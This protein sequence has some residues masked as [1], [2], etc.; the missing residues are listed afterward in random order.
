MD[1]VWEDKPANFS[2]VR[3]MLA[4]THFPDGGLIVLPELFATGF[5]MNSKA[6]VEDDLGE[7][8]TFLIELA[9]E[10]SAHVIGGVA[11]TESTG[12]NPSNCSV[13]SSPDGEII[14]RYQKTHPFSLGDEHEN[15]SPGNTVETVDFNGAR[16]CPTVCYDL[17]FP[18][19]F[20]IG[21][22]KGAE[23]FVVIANWPDKRNQHWITLLQAR[24][25]ENQAFV[26]GVN[27][28]GQDPNL[29]YLGSTIAVNFLGEIIAD[30][31]T[32]AG[33]VEADL[34]L[35]EVREWRANFPA[36]RDIHGSLS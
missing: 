1:I 9:R 32:T 3:E 20:R 28:S 33:V 10:K 24:A 5:T 30:A 23:I 22:E 15:Y 18:E 19:L 25:I 29:G 27:R 35:D 8:E 31:G 13:V 14:C 7:T 26:L 4:D 16:F 21:A 2:L 6:I 17:R 36:L 34:N 12:E 11:K